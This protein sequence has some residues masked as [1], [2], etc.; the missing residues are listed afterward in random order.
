[1][2][3][4]PTPVVAKLFD[5][6]LNVDCHV[7]LTFHTH[8]AVGIRACQGGGPSRADGRTAARQEVIADRERWRATRDVCFHVSPERP[9]V[10]ITPPTKVDLDHTLYDVR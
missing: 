5:S 4:R 3:L 9:S 7:K 6:V 8:C 2:L 1:L 10:D